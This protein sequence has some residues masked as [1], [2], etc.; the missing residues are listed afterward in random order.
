MS[1]RS[2]QTE[3]ENTSR[4]R[5]T[6][7]DEI[8]ENDQL[9]A[10]TGRYINSLNLQGQ[11]NNNTIT[12]AQALQIAYTEAEK[13]RREL[14]TAIN[15]QS[16]STNNQSNLSIETNMAAALSNPDSFASKQADAQIEEIILAE[17]ITQLTVQSEINEQQVTEMQATESRQEESKD[18]FVP[19]D[20]LVGAAFTDCVSSLSKADDAGAEKA[21]KDTIEKATGYDVSTEPLN[22]NEKSKSEEEDKEKD[23]DKD[24]DESKDNDMV[25]RPKPPKPE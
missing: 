4:K 15:T 1:R 18:G 11:I 6:L 12:E 2:W 10:A 3:G 20:E 17:M 21:V 25:L 14:N 22:A 19:D 24:K 23:K 16:L 7:F 13:F 5:K 8:L 9:Q